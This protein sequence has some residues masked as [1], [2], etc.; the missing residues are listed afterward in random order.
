MR[1]GDV[2][3]HE[4]FDAHANR[5]D[6][7]GAIIVNLALA[8]PGISYRAG[9]VEDVD[10][11]ARA[12]E[13]T[14]EAAAQVLQTQLSEIAPLVDDWP[15]LL[16]EDLLRDP[17]RRLDQ[18][19]DLHGI[20]PETVS[21]GFGRIYG[22]SAARFRAEIRVRRALREITGTRAPLVE[23]AMQSGHSDQAHMTR[24]IRALTGAPPSYWRSRSISFKTRAS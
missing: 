21:R 14:P 18:W 5:F 4:P 13:Q 23:I 8:L 9:R 20:A 16:A 19:A 6:T 3:L 1:A 22:T 2:L 11:I 15:D 7:R 12:A 17:D 24:A 10:A